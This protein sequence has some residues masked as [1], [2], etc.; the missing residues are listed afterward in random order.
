M[1]IIKAIDKIF[2]AASLVMVP[3]SGWAFVQSIIAML[4]FGLYPELIV[5]ALFC[6]SAIVFFYLFIGAQLGVLPKSIAQRLP[7]FSMV[8]ATST[9]KERQ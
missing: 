9:T 8:D 2:V 3:A 6:L 5:V 1:K 7:F 4:Y